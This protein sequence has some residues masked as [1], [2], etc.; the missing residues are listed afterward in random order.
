MKLYAL[1]HHHVRKQ[2]QRVERKNA[3]RSNK[4]LFCVI[5]KSTTN[6]IALNVNRSKTTNSFRSLFDVV[7]IAALS[8]MAQTQLFRCH[9]RVSP[10]PAIIDIN[11]SLMQ[12]E[13][14]TQR[15]I[16]NV[17]LCRSIIILE[18]QIE[19]QLGK[20]LLLPSYEA[21]HNHFQ[22]CFMRTFPGSVSIVHFN[23][24]PTWHHARVCLV[25]LFVTLLAYAHMSMPRWYARMRRHHMKMI[26][27]SRF[28]DI[29]DGCDMLLVKTRTPSDG[30]PYSCPLMFHIF[31]SLPMQLASTPPS[32]PWRATLK[33][34]A[35]CVLEPD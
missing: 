1:L 25:F 9:S 8:I 6:G 15:T 33:K 32:S 12:V 22:G 10:T 16:V 5:T 11:E 18:C 13:A 34:R 24:H 17:V 4:N 31:K 23:L 30:N 28:G 20:V 29:V 26:A 19:T 14:W 21:L 7:Q 2:S 35:R 27:I 3:L